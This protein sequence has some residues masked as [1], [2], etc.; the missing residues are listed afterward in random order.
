MKKAGVDNFP[1]LQ[2]TSAFTQECDQLFGLLQKLIDQAQESILCSRNDSSAQLT[3][4]DLPRVLGGSA[5]PPE[6]PEP[7]PFDPCSDAFRASRIREKYAENVGQV[8]FTRAAENSK[9][10]RRSVGGTDSIAE[11][12]RKLQAEHVINIEKAQKAGFDTTALTAEL[13]APKAA[14]RHLEHYSDRVRALADRGITHSNHWIVLGGA[15]RNCKEALEGWALQEEREQSAKDA[16][17]TKEKDARR[18]LKKTVR[19]ALAPGTDLQKLSGNDLKALL[20]YFMKEGH[21]KHTA[22]A[23]IIQKIEE[24]W[25]YVSDSDSD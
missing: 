9:H 14:P 11:K 7:L 12:L 5:C 13:P 10:C 23:D 4:K 21:S 18:E 22:K 8:P 19:K 24:H 2:N 25:H 15:P 20:K 6:F 3:L 17:T 1:K 16:K